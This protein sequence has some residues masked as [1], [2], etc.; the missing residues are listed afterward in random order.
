MTLRSA[1]DVLAQ[2]DLGVVDGIEPIWL[3]VGPFRAKVIC[4]DPMRS[5]LQRYFAPA[6]GKAGSADI[7]VLVLEGQS[8]SSMPEWR[9]WAREPGKSGR[10]D[11]TFDLTD[12]RLIRKVRTGLTFLQSKAA[13]IA[14]GP[15]ADNPNQIVNFVNT[16]I[17]NLAQHRGWQ[18]CHAAALTSGVKTLAISGLSGGGKSTTVLRL[19]DLDGLSFVTNDRLLVRAGTPHPDG[20]GIPKEPRINPGTILHNTRLHPMLSEA[21]LAELS[22]MAPG[23]LWV[24]EEKHDLFIADVY[25]SDRVRYDAPLTDFWVLNWSRD[26]AAPT[27]VTKVDLAARP[28]LLGAIMKSPG[29]FFQK[30]DG[31]FLTDTET[32]EPEDYLAALR[33]VRVSEI[34]GCI[35]FDHLFS[36]GQVLFND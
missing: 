22:A 10:K 18:I 4:A 6:L 11:A 21:R 34:S 16:Q 24:L 1:V 2:L 14:F 29:P 35:D 3:S 25:G 33:G 28:D 27:Q 12:G 31:T 17:L 36:A 7:E 8:L 5:E 20:L 23:A 30:P 32:P 9:D 15:C 19:M 26:S 13:V